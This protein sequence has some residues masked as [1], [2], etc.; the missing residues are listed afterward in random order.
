MLTRAAR[1]TTAEIISREWIL[2][3]QLRLIYRTSFYISLYIREH[4]WMRIISEGLMSF[5]VFLPNILRIDSPTL[6]VT[7]LVIHAE[8]R[9]HGILIIHPVS[10]GL[11][12]MY[13]IYYYIGGS[14]I[15]GYI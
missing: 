14:S 12:C 2:L 8:E 10:C 1:R 5:S 7:H 15:I 4:P 11:Y 13:P 3:K 9:Y 6:P